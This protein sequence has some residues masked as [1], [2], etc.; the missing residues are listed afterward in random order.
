MSDR[1]SAEEKRR[2][3]PTRCSAAAVLRVYHKRLLD[4]IQDPVRAAASLYSEGI[5]GNVTNQDLIPDQPIY[6]KNAIVL[7]AVRI[8]VGND[9]GKMDTFLRVLENTAIEEVVEAMRKDMGEC[10]GWVMCY[11]MHNTPC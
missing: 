3:V 7:E 9:E 1:L 8:G 6:K 4:A 10:D 5:V 2:A 11:C